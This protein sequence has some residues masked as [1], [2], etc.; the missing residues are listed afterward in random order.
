MVFW[1]LI[2]HD[3]QSVRIGKARF[4]LYFLQLSAS[5]PHCSSSPCGH[6]SRRC[7]LLLHREV[8]VMCYVLLLCV[9]CYCYV[10]CVIVMCGGI[11]EQQKLYTYTYTYIYIPKYT[12][13]YIFFNQFEFLKCFLL[14]FTISHKFFFHDLK[15]TTTSQEKLMLGNNA[16]L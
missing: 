6:S 14:N 15:R 11:H 16:F 3:S 4:L 1:E 2:K 7:P 12:Y 10:L 13:T 9:M 8:I 5:S